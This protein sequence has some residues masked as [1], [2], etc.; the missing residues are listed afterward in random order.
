MTIISSFSHSYYQPHHHHYISKILEQILEE[1]TIW[2]FLIQPF[3]DF[4][5]S[6]KSEKHH[7][8]HALAVI[9]NKELLV[10]SCLYS[11][12]CMCAYPFENRHLN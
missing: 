4:E 11:Y 8:N 2:P 12:V 10:Q 1:M 5:Q 6:I 7:L 3:T 9:G